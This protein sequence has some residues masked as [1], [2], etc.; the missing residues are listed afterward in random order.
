ME[1][2][3]ILPYYNRD[4]KI[5]NH[6]KNLPETKKESDQLENAIVNTFF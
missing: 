3:V 1:Y 6:S 5:C 2:N 4:S